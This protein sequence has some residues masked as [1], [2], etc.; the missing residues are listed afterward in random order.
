M[1]LGDET[2]LRLIYDRNTDSVD[3]FYL[4]MNLNLMCKTVMVIR[5]SFINEASDLQKTVFRKVTTVV[6]TLFASGRVSPSLTK[7]TLLSQIEPLMQGATLT[8]FF[9][10]YM[11][12]PI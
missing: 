7:L 11:A 1:L 4:K 6:L 3:Q 2:W 10:L 8:T 5:H 9:V 12:L